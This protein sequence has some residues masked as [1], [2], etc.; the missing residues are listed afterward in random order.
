MFVSG[1]L[2]YELKKYQNDNKITDTALVRV[3]RCTI[4]EHLINGVLTKAKSRSIVWAQEEPKNMGAWTFIVTSSRQSAFRE[5]AGGTDPLRGRDCV[6]V[7][8]GTTK[9][10]VIEQ[11]QII[12][13]VYKK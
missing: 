9:R 10:H 3:E 4:S 13:S 7:R 2:Y 11:N 12:E 6:P 1:K 8:D 5:V